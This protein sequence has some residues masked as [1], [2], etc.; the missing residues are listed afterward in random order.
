MTEDRVNRFLD[1]KERK[2]KHRTGNVNEKKRTF[3]YT[4]KFVVIACIVTEG[5]QIAAECQQ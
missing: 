5:S 2:S 1:L 3:R 4:Q